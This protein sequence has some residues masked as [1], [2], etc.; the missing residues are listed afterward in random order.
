MIDSNN[1]PVIL[2]LHGWGFSKSV[3]NE[4]TPL[5]E[6]EYRILTPDLRD[7]YPGITVNLKKHLDELEIKNPYIVA[8]SMGFLIGLKL[9]ERIKI[10]KLVSLAAVPFFCCENG[11]SKDTVLQ[12]K[13]GLETSPDRVI[14]KFKQWV[15]Y[16]DRYKPDNKQAPVNYDSNFMKETLSLLE[17]NDLRELP[18]NKNTM[19]FFGEKDAV[20]PI[21]AIESFELKRSFI[22]EDSG[23]NFFIKNKIGLAD[24]IKKFFEEF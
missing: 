19:Y 16:P 3:W 14:R 6:N 10:N 24:R 2:F 7:F 9:A 4:I 13:K 22:Y 1:K 5:F 23:H 12:M 15:Y 18:Y 8:W 21:K 11:L 17:T 20:L